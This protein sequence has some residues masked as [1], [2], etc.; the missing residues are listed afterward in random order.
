MGRQNV[1]LIINHHRARATPPSPRTRT[2]IGLRS[3]TQHQLCDAI[4]FLG[5][6]G[7]RNS[8]W[9][10]LACTDRICL[11]LSKYRECY[12]G[13]SIHE[14][15]KTCK[16]RDTEKGSPTFLYSVS[17]FSHLFLSSFFPSFDRSLSGKSSPRFF[18]LTGSSRDKTREGN[19]IRTRITGT[20]TRERKIEKRIV[21]RPKG[22]EQNS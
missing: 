1:N 19:N 10:L 16:S 14:K 12:R 15:K 7:Q 21:Q 22:C 18:L 5:E 8:A 11:Y 20:G 2:R 13:L 3:H 9:V 17:I 6:Q 4:Y